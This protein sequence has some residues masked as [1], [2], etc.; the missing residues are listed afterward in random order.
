MNVKKCPYCNKELPEELRFCPYCMQSLIPVKTHPGSGTKKPVWVVSAAVVL[1]AVVLAAA[2]AGGVGWHQSGL[3]TAVTPAEVPDNEQIVLPE[4]QSS[5]TQQPVSSGSQPSSPQQ[6]VSPEFMLPFLPQKP[7]NGSPQGS[8]SSQAGFSSGSSLTSTSVSAVSSLPESASS[9]TPQSNTSSQSSSS[10]EE[11]I[12]PI[13]QEVYDRTKLLVPGWIS[14]WNRAAVNLGL[15]DYKVQTYETKPAYSPTW[16]NEIRLNLQ[17]KCGFEV[18]ELTFLKSESQ[19]FGTNT[20]CLIDGSI[21]IPKEE[22]SLLTY[23]RVKYL[24]LATFT[25][26][27]NPDFINTFYSDEDWGQMGNK[28]AGVDNG[29]SYYKRGMYHGFFFD[30]LACTVL[31]EDEPINQSYIEKA[32]T[33]IMY[34][35]GFKIEKRNTTAWINDHEGYID[36]S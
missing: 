3:S 15:P 35:H 31:F 32:G 30:D 9:D 28:N 6:A 29:Y 26:H 1:A 20:G 27:E 8:V 11:T 5:F 25:G 17:L 19:Q 13:A 18:A 4:S 16:E 24:I 34:H 12:S 2:I 22:Q 36:Y 33:N 21:Y 10:Q 14:A 7:D 23:G